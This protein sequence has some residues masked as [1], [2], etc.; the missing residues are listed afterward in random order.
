MRRFAT[1]AAVFGLR[2][3]ALARFS[4]EESDDESG[5][6]SSCIAGGDA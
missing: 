5:S 3:R 6:R 2:L 1:A 4:T